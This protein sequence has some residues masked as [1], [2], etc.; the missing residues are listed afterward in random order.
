MNDEALL[1]G[2]SPKVETVPDLGASR[3]SSRNVGSLRDFVEAQTPD[4]HVEP[5]LISKS[6][7]LSISVW[8]QNIITAL[9]RC[10]TS[11][12]PFVRHAI[13]LPRAAKSSVSPA[14]PLPLPYVGIFAKMP[15][16]LSSIRR[17]RVHF[18]RA[19]T[20]IVLALNFWWNG[21]PVL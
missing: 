2:V 19:V 9:F 12:V 5:A 4:E 14:F 1:I 10:R 16:G 11:F 6:S 8:C 17:A 13:S 21:G 15:S 18:R 3:L 7:K 20:V